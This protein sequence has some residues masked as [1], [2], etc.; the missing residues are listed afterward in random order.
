MEPVFPFKSGFITVCYPFL[1]FCRIPVP[2]PET[3]S[4]I[5]GSTP[6]MPSSS[7]CMLL[8]WWWWFYGDFVEV[9]LYTYCY[10]IWFCIFG[11]CLPL[12]NIGTLNR[13]V[14]SYFCF[15]F[16]LYY[17]K[18]LS[19]V[20]VPNCSEFWTSTSLNSPRKR[21]GKKKN[22]CLRRPYK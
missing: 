6:S 11:L 1:I 21:N 12:A 13:Y 22:G 3:S 8:W 19:K 4:Q 15:Y 7:H 14:A 20:L 5:K 17:L 9:L 18:S 10:L 16:Y 2:Q